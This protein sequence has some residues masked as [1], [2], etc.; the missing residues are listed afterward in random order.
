MMRLE[1]AGKGQVVAA[2]RLPRQE[3]VAVEPLVVEEIAIVGEIIDLELGRVVLRKGVEDPRVQRVLPRNGRRRVVT[4]GPDN[5]A[6]Y[7]TARPDQGRRQ[8]RR[9]GIGRSDIDVARLSG[10]DRT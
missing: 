8:E 9:G 2:R 1:L 6:R 3:V 7:Q 4:V 5:R 10:L